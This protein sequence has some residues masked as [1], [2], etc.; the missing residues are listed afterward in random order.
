MLFYLQTDGAWQ[1]GWPDLTGGLVGAVAVA[2][3]FVAAVTAFVVAGRVS[4]DEMRFER[5]APRSSWLVAGVPFIG[6]F[7]HTALG[8]SVPVLYALVVIARSGAPGAPGSTSFAT[9]CAYLL[10][11]I[12]VGALAGRL[13]ASRRFAPV[14]VLVAMYGF[15]A[16]VGL[17]T[18]T[19][20]WEVPSIPMTAVLGGAGAMMLL[21]AVFSEPLR[22]GSSRAA[23]GRSGLAILVAIVAFAGA[24]SAGGEAMTVSRDLVDPVC[25]DD[26]RV[27]VWPEHAHHLDEIA[28][29][30]VR[31]DLYRDVGLRIDGPMYERGLRS[32]EGPTFAYPPAWFAFAG[33]GSAVTDRFWKC[34]ESAVITDDT[35]NASQQLMVWATVVAAGGMPPASVGGGPAEVSLADIDRVR[36]LPA[37]QER[38]WLRG[39]I[40]EAERACG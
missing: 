16:L 25:T 3:P 21:A 22:R 32:T 5:A 27:C 39:R 37:A 2:A 20:A 6:A 4:P 13:S 9:L 23:L 11:P 8:V 7:V 1:A 10:F 40:A 17:P 24:F 26:G 33:M 31:L 36:H 18:N 38:A 34:G 29:G 19:P 30:L 12:A 15:I 28:A 35:V 14:V